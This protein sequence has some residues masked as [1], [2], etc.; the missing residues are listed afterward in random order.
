M[1]QILEPDLL[2]P[3]AQREQAYLF[4]CQHPIIGGLANQPGNPPDLYH[5]YL[6]LAAVSLFGLKGLQPLNPLVN[7]S[8]RTLSHLI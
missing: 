2:Q 7:V 4:A 5:T 6:S 1:P 8:K 3:N